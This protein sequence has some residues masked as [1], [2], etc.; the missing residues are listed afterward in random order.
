M[1]AGDLIKNSSKVNKRGLQVQTQAQSKRTKASQ[2]WHDIDTNRYFK[3]DASSG[4]TMKV[5]AVGDNV[6]KYY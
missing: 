6:K 1:E 2:L 3:I 5:N 4:S